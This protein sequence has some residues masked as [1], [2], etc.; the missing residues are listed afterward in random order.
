MQDWLLNDSDFLSRGKGPRLKL[1]VETLDLA[2]ENAQDF[3]RLSEALCRRAE[4]I[5]PDGG[6]E[7][8]RKYLDTPHIYSQIITGL[9][10]RCRLC[11]N[12][13]RLEC[14]NKEPV[15]IR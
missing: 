5:L 2:V 1:Y 12:C 13:K 9:G 15:S 6:P 14:L 8:L 11:D 4:A 7:H 10:R 3:P